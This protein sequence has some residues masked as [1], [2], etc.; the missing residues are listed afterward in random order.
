MNL[1]LFYFFFLCA[2]L[3]LAFIF[4]MG[5][6]WISRLLGFQEPVATRVLR[7]CFIAV[8]GEEL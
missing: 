8:K 5:G 4:G 7:R 1:A 6:L 3:I 2:L